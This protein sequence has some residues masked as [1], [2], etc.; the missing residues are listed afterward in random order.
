[1][2]GK[3]NANVFTKWRGSQARDIIYFFRIQN[4]LN[5]IDVRDLEDGMGDL[6]TY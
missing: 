4:R 6:L 2:L 5:P 1:M 3:S